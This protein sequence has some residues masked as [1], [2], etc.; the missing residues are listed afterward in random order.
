MVDARPRSNGS[1][2]SSG[3][4]AAACVLVVAGMTGATFAAVP[5]Y[6]VFAEATGYGGTT[7]QASAAPAQ[8]GDRFVTVRFNSNIANN[9]GWT[10]RPLQHQ[11]DVRLGSVGRV[12]FMA[13][14]RTSRSET[15]H[16]VF[17]VTPDAVGAYF[18]KI[19]CFCFTDQTLAPGQ[20][21]EMGVT[22]FVDPAYARDPDLKSV[23]TITLSYT[24]FPAKAGEPSAAAA[25]VTANVN[26]NAL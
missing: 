12:S 10:F 6:H 18:N 17:N 1:G 2:T 21:A 25:E 8:L 13:E 4:I 7:R 20:S 14:N 9:L 5:L 19:A 3:A 24:F 16:A 15:G 11:I 23:D 22:F 26:G